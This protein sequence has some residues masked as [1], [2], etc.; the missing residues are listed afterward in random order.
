MDTPKLY[1][2]KKKFIE[3][4]TDISMR[5]PKD[6]LREIDSIA[7]QKGRNRNEVLV[8]A[9]EFALDHLQEKQD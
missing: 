8:L 5:L 4:S 6:M 2:S 3:D 7:K 1:I 9:L